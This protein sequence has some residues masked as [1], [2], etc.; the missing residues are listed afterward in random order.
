MAMPL[1][2]PTTTMRGIK[3]TA[4]PKPV[5]PISNSTMPAISVTIAKPLMPKRRTI[6]ATITT[7]APVGPPIWVREPPSA[8]IRKPGHHSRVETGL[9]ADA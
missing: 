8:E 6:P 1:V 4:A 7:K 9:R 3:R 5:S 2:K